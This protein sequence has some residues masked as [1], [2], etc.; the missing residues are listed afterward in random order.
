MSR[1]HECERC[2]H[3]CVRHVLGQ[4]P[5]ISSAFFEI[6]YM[7]ILLTPASCACL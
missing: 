2:T 6:A 1:S 7:S 4:L 5:Q 3:E